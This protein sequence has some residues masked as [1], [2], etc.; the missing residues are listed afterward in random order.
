[1]RNLNLK[2]ILFPIFVLSAMIIGLV[3]GFYE[4]RFSSPVSTFGI[5]FG[6]FFMIYPAMTKVRLDQFSS[7]LKNFKNISLMLF[8][9]YVIDPLLVA[10]LAY[11]MFDYVFIKTD[12][13]SQSVATEAII[14]VILLGV[15]PC[16]AMVMVWTDMSKGNL[17]MAVS[18]VAW[19]S[20]IQIV[21]TPLLVLLLTRSIVVVD[22]GLILESILLYLALPLLAGILTR[23]F[24]SKRSSFAKLLNLLGNVQTVALLFTITVMFWSEGYGII[25]YPNLIWMVGIVMVLF[26]F[27]LFHI[28]YFSSR[29]LRMNYE[30]ST[31]IG[32][33]VAARDFE[34]SI[35]IAIAAFSTYPFVPIV[36]AIGPL[37]EIPFMLMLVALQ[38]KRRNNIN[39]AEMTI[40]NK[41][42]IHD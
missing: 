40:E 34:L 5:P 12:L 9:N 26:Y 22:P 33:S 25:R 30:D 27:I 29:K 41:A 8:L 15:A 19:N 20:G 21:T 10:G 3:F 28:G 31:A 24:L 7:S 35:A 1:M 32:Y 39:S 17:P 37:L 4:R 18:F 36:T 23:H 38:L 2:T 42:N 16:I 11:F 13:I 6:L 14:G